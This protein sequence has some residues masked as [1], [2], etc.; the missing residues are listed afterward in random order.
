MTLRNSVKIKVG[1]AG[2]E[3]I[4]KGLDESEVFRAV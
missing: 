2:F 4:G 3:R 1:F